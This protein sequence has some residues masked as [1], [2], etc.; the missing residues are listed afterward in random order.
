[1]LR[2]LP[3]N[4]LGALPDKPSSLHLALE[5]D[6]ALA[7]LKA[8]A[9]LVGL[10]APFVAGPALGALGSMTAVKRE[11]HAAAPAGDDR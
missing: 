7:L 5:L 1:V 9:E 3:E 11:G 10:E 4:L 2:I 8:A 6:R